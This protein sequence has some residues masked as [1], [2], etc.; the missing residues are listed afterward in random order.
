MNKI[1]FS[2]CFVAL[3]INANAQI[4]IAQKDFENNE[5]FK[6]AQLAFSIIDVSNGN[7]IAKKN[8][9]TLMYPASLQKLITTNMALILAGKDYQYETT[10]YMGDSVS[11]GTLWG[12][13][14]IDASGDPTLNSSNFNADFLDKVAKALKAKGI[15]TINGNVL[16]KNKEKIFATQTWLYEDVANYYAAIPLL[17]NYKDN[18]YTISFKSGVNNTTPTVNSIT[19]EVPYTFEYLLKSSETTKGDNAYILGTPFSSARQITGTITANTDNFKIKGANANPVYSFAQDLSK[20]I[21]ISGLETKDKKEVFLTKAVSVPLHD[22]A[23]Y[24]NFESD[25]FLAETLLKTLGH[26]TSKHFS[27]ED[28]IKAVNN[29]FSLSKLNDK[30]IILKD[31]SGL[32]RLNAITPNFLSEYLCTFYENKDFVKTLPIAGESGTMKYLNNAGI[33]GKILGKSGSADG[34]INYAGYIK[35]NNGKTYAFTIMTNNAY[36]SKSAIR[37]A[38]GEFLAAVV[39]MP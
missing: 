11:D 31:G 2:L 36:S 20:Q 35:A 15:S 12:N 18:S 28:G 23:K 21:K 34:V 5:V 27:T 1:I 3:F 17:F 24:C 10:V 39:N 37:K 19:P 16:L 30:E 14:T 25:N 38:I 26:N 13:L 6:N 9:H 22:I 32:S 33:K 7:E 8:E 29:F 4:S